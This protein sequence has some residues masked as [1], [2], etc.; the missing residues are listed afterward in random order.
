MN[1]LFLAANVLYVLLAGYYYFMLAQFYAAVVTLQPL[2]ESVPSSSKLWTTLHTPSF[3]LLSPDAGSV[4]VLVNAP[5]LPLV[6]ST[7]V[8][9]SLALLLR[10]G[11]GTRRPSWLAVAASI[12]VQIVTAVL[13]ILSPFI[14]FLNATVLS[15]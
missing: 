9:V 14:D 6:F 12:A 3:G 2:V 8:L 11:T 5:L 13:L 4:L 10:S 1:Q 15:S 7:F